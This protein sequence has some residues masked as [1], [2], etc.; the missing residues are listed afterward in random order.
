M[1]LKKFLARVLVDDGCWH[2][3][4]AK[5]KGGY[6]TFKVDGRYSS[7]RTAHSLMCE[8]INGPPP[9]ATHTYALHRCNNPGCVRPSHIFWGNQRQ[10]VKQSYDEGR[11]LSP[12]EYLFR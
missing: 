1:D 10:N 12:S 9:D 4:G 11:R 3:I 2:W 7:P 6:G 5:T 8:L